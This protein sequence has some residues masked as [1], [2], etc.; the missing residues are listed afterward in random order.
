LGGAG[1][2]DGFAGVEPLGGLLG[3]GRDVGGGVAGRLG[4][5]VAGRLVCD[6][7]RAALDAS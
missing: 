2:G 1:C 5:G 7:G 6:D 4:V 3:A